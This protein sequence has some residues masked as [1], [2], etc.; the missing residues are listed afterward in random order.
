LS[1]V[2]GPT[3]LALAAIPHELAWRA[4]LLPKLGGM[5]RGRA[6]LLTGLLNGMW[7]APLLFADAAGLAKP[8]LAASLF[9]GVCI[10]FGTVLAEMWFR[11]QHLGLSAVAMGAFLG[12]VMGVYSHIVRDAA[13]PW[14]GSFG[15]I[16]IAAWLV[17]AGVLRRSR[18][19]SDEAG[20]AGEQ[21][22]PT[23][24]EEG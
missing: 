10:A 20:E 13:W 22:A 23:P 24:P 18:L 2:A 3:L 16:A 12:Q 1:I 19:A 17:L 8:W 21:A 9:L 5:G 7:F 14:G 15:V 11:F 4:Y 6:A